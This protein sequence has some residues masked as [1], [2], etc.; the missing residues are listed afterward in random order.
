MIIVQIFVNLGKHAFVMFA[1][2]SETLYKVHWLR[3]QLFTV[4][5]KDRGDKGEGTEWQGD[6]SAG[7][8]STDFPAQSRLVHSICVG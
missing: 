8:E 7:D 5:Q 1:Q 6:E 4:T 3:T 2:I